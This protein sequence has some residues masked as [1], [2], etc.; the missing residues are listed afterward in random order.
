MTRFRIFALAIAWVVVSSSVISAQ[1]LSRYREFQ[2]GMRMVTVAQQAG[3]TPEPHVLLRRPALIQELMWQPPRVSTSLLQ[4][5]SV[6]KVLFRFYN[7]Q[8]F[9][10]VVTYDRERT[11]GLTAEDLVDAIS[12]R[13]GLARLHVTEKPSLAT[14]PYGT[15]EIVAQWEDSQHSLDLYSSPQL[16]TFALVVV[17][18]RIDALAQVATGEA[19][20]DAQGAPQQAIE[21]QRT[22]TEGDRVTQEARRVNKSTFRP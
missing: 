2:L 18:K 15:N 9:R 22:Q 10:M 12:T 14:A 19:T 11:L 16:S 17:S 20:L 13:D 1:D 21:R 7:D 4:R 6:G 5:E 8:L 3:I